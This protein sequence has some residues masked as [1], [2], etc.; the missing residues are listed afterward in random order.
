MLLR[1]STVPARFA[2]VFFALILKPQNAVNWYL[3]GRHL[4]HTLDETDVCRAIQ[5]YRHAISVSPRSV[6]ARLGFADTR[7]VRVSVV[8]DAS[9]KLESQI[10]GS[11]WI[12]EVALIP[13]AAGNP[14]P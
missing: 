1:L 6:A 5:N 4:Q 11:A 14:R 2:T 9:G 3:L 8:R 12:D 7:Q 10:R 13:D